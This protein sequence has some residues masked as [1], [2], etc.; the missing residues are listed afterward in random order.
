MQKALEF[1][2]LPAIYSSDNPHEYLQS[3]LG[4]YLEQEINQEGMTRNLGAF[5][6][7]LQITSFSQG[8]PI[9]TSSIAREV[10]IH[11]KV[12]D[13]YFSILIDLLIGSFLPAFTRRAKRRLI[14]KSKFYLF[15]SGIYNTARPKGYLDKNTEVDGISLETLFLNHLLAI[16]E[17]CRYEYKFSYFRTASGL[18]VDFIAYGPQGF[19][20]FE[21]KLTKNIYSN[22]LKGLIAF[23]RDYPE[24][25]LHLLYTGEKE[26]YFGNIT[27]TPI[28]NALSNLSKILKKQ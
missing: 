25:K 15:D 28:I 17:Y 6:R 1:G 24:A 7:F 12:V 16:N 2:T 10:G 4:T 19:H 21:I 5:Y 3:Y 8:S 26:L 13:N 9:N 18:E 14:S 22:H 11:N 23:S 20:A 27:V